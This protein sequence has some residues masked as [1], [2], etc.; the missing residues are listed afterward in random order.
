[1]FISGF[2]FVRNAVKFDYPIMESIKSV[3]PICDEFVVLVGNSEDKTLEL[4]NNINS[5]KIKIINSIWNDNLRKGGKVLAIET[6][7]AFAYIS[8]KADW[9]FYIQADEI[10][11]EKY[12]DKIYYELS[13]YLNNKNVDGF[14]FGFRH[15][16]GSYNYI[17][18]SQNWYRNEIRIIRNC[19]RIYSYRDAQGFRKNINKKLQVKKIDAFIYHYGWVKN[20]I[21][22]LQKQLNFNKLWHED[23]FCNNILEK[24]EFDYA[25]NV[26]SLT[27]FD[28]V[29]PSV[30][31]ERIN[32]IN[33]DF[34]FH[35]NSIKINLLKKARI[36]IEKLCGYRIG[37]YKNYKLL[38]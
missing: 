2:T 7:K 30:M 37:E 16:Y 27:Y 35:N 36:L 28:G 6:N 10:L 8:D 24:A 17:V 38:K 15:F 20:P 3:L 32:N 11:H 19:S 21:N 34:T 33:W 14:L 26:D 22:Q 23:E 4:I 5:P 18:N 31:N 1:M 25:Q 12:Y 9:A 13:K 29:H